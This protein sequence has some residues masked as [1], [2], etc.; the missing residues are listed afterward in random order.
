MQGRAVALLGWSRAGVAMEQP[1]RQAFFWCKVTAG[2]WE[3]PQNL[4]AVE[5]ITGDLLS[6]CLPTFPE[7]QC[8]TTCV[9]PSPLSPT[10]PVLTWGLVLTALCSVAV[11]WGPAFTRGNVR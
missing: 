10:S 3:F 5:T 7:H 8:W 2:G 11:T 6:H 9:P 4:G 1:H